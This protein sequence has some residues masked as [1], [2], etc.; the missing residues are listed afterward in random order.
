M[1]IEYNYQLVLSHFYQEIILVMF[2][3]I[4]LIK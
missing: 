3:F 4:F 2:W 1:T